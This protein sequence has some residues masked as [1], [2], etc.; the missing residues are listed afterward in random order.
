MEAHTFQLPP[1]VAN[2][3]AIINLNNKDNQCFKWAVTRALNSVKDHSECIDTKIIKST[4]K[5]NWDGITFP[6]NLKQIDRFEKNPTISVNVFG[7]EKKN[8]TI[9]RKSETYKRANIV[10][11]LLINDGEVQNYCVIKN[12]SRLISSQY[13]KHH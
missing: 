2:K 7:Y 5:Y 13:N 11:L 12:L 4:E 10:D 9:L 8:V 1:E 3:K 6:V